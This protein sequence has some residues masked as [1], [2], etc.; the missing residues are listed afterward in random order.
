MCLVSAAH[1][2]PI[3][4]FTARGIDLVPIKFTPTME[5]GLALEGGELQLTRSYLLQALLDFNV[6]ILAAKNGNERIGDLM[7]FRADLHLMGAYQLHPR[8]EVSADL[9]ITFAQVNNF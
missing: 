6:G 7:P 4:P 2:Q 3:D 5:S 8:V 1:A 9:P